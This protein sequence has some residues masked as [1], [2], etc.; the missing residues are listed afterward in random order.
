MLG[1]C[2]NFITDNKHERLILEHAL[3]CVRYIMKT[4][5][6]VITN[7]LFRLR[8]QPVDAAHVLNRCATVRNH[9][10]LRNICEFR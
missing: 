10:N 5:N 8:V 2:I 3:N 7:D 9:I 1:Y 6:I 4:T